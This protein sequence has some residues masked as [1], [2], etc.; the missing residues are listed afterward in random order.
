M[1]EGDNFYKVEILVSKIDLDSKIE[2][3]VDFPSKSSIIFDII[4][5]SGVKVYKASINSA[6]ATIKERYIDLNISDNSE[7][8]TRKGFKRHTIEG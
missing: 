1:K 5:K 6:R 4:E 3:G 2:K 7:S 8:T